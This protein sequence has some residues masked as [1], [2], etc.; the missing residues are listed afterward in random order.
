MKYRNTSDW[1]TVQKTTVNSKLCYDLFL[2]ME[3]IQSERKFHAS[4]QFLATKSP[5]IDFIVGNIHLIIIILLKC[6]RHYFV[7][8]EYWRKNCC[9]FVSFPPPNGTKRV[10]KKSLLTLM[11]KPKRS[12]SESIKL[13][14][15][16][17]LTRTR[18]HTK[19]TAGRVKL[20]LFCCVLLPLGAHKYTHFCCV[21]DGA[22]ISK[23]HKMNWA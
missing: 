15:T 17:V 9:F 6:T 21:V 12:F 7:Q 3:I 13:E 8:I 22:R 14:Q 20:I 1:K 18:K 2:L 5:I 11:R 4:R 16:C 19:W 23:C 10:R